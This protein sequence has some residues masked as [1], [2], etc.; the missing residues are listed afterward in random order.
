MGQLEDMT[1]FIRVVE[2]GGISKAAEQLGMAKSA[3]SRRLLELETRLGV[4]LLNRTTRTSS[5]TEAGEHYY[6][7]SIRIADDVMELNA[8]TMDANVALAGNINLAAPLS[9]GISHLSTAIDQFVSQHPGIHINIDFSDRKVDLVEEGLDL[10]FRIARLEDSSLVARQICPIR[11]LL[12]A[13][14]DYLDK[15]GEPQTLAELQ[16]HQ[17][18]HYNMTGHRYWQLVDKE[19]KQHRVKVDSRV[20]AN[21]G[22]FLKDMAIAGH[23][24][25]ATPTFI[26]WQALQQGQLVPVMQHYQPLPVN[27]YAVYPRNRY[28]SQRLRAFIDFLIERFGDSPYWDN[29]TPLVTR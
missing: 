26:S 9:F 19:G 28:L 21:N 2:A 27:A 22:E 18:L 5:L 11:I 6:E 4:K 7:R 29:D 17:L 25:V 23:G 10:A 24:I 12:C 14:P 15:H 20:E 3:V 1:V 16:Q 8:L 13:S